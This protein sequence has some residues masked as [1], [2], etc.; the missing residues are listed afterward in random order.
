MRNISC[1]PPPSPIMLFFFGGRFFEGEIGH[2][3]F[4]A[5]A[6]RRRSFN[7]AR[8]RGARRVAGSRLLP[9]QGT[10]STSHS[11][12]MRRCPGRHSSAMPPPPASPSSTTRGSS[13]GRKVSTRRAST[14]LIASSA[15]CFSGPDF[16]LIFPPCGYDDPKILPTRKP[17]TVSKALTADR[18]MGQSRRAYGWKKGSRGE[19]G[20]R[21]LGVWGEGRHRHTPKLLDR[22]RGIYAWVRLTGEIPGPADQV[23]HEADA[24]E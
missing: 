16:R 4:N 1:P 6:S 24:E 19:N 8:K 12:S 23:C 17:P 7:L 18:R 20:G 13:L 11:T 22:R 9:A 5:C 3:P 21:I 2:D 10:L 14:S 15:G